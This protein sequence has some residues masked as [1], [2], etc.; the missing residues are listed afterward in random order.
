MLRLALRPFARGGI[1]LFLMLLHYAVSAHEL[2]KPRMDFVPPAPGS[3]ALNAIQPVA[4]G[5]V[6]E[7][8]GSPHCLAR[9]TTGKITLLSFVYTYCTDPTGCPLAYRTFI[10]LYEQI[11]ATPAMHGRV[12]LVSLSFDPGNDT[13][14]AMKQYGGSHAGNGGPLPWHFLTTRSVDDLLPILDGFGQDVAVDVDDG[15]RPL[16]TFSHMLKVFLIDRRGMVREVYTTAFL[17]PQVIF[18]DIGTL[19]L[20]EDRKLPLTQI[21]PPR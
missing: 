10:E 8:D 21:L 5:N 11:R 4:E 13:P 9:F 16:R 15:G 20:E 18:N 12:R 2:P 17:L 14:S 3:Y 1:F 19:L 7:S 6:L